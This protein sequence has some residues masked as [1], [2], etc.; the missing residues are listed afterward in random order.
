MTL[1][2]VYDS[3]LSR[4]R[5]TGTYPEPLNSNPYFETDIAGWEPQGG[6]LA[7]STVQARTGTGSAL[8]TPDGVSATVR[9]RTILASSPTVFAGETNEFSVWVRS[10]NGYD[11]D[12]SVNYFDAADVSLEFAIWA[13]DTIPAA[14][15]TRIVGTG[16]APVGAVKAQLH[17]NQRNT[18]AVGDT[19]Y[20]DDAEFR[21]ISLPAVE[22]S[23]DQVRWSTIRGGADVTVLADAWKLDD[24]EFEPDVVNYYRA[25]GE[26]QSI[27]PTLTRVWLKSISRPWL[28][29]E[30]TV[31]DFSDV[32][33]QA[34]AGVFD[35]VGR[36]F[37][38]AV[39]DVRSGKSYT[40]ELLTETATEERDLDIVIASGDPLFVQPPATSRVPGGYYTVGN[41]A[42]RRLART[43]PKRVFSLP[44]A[45]VAAPG[46]D[47]IGAT[48]TCQTVLNTYATCSA[49]LA[50]H[51]TCADLLELIG[52]PTEVIVP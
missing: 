29:R 9:A 20:V 49:V 24:Y 50:A 51:P 35:I 10:T 31:V 26:V 41:T 16:V 6:T 40:L 3:Q 18:P 11:V 52:D 43:S 22:R 42:D 27:T 45:E 14:T 34:R 32:T 33:R 38:I 47:V 46:P 39:S 37:P 7:H 23:T 36:S 4:V 8:L 12:I 28:N 44:L 48:S 15:W 30:V 13:G 2:A 21:V 19:L 17:V 1:A 25:R 5:L